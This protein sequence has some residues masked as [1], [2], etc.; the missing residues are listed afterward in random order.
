MGS[1]GGENIKVSESDA[2]E[3]S[4]TTIDIKI[5]TLDSKTFSVQVDKCVSVAELKEKIASLNGVLSE[6]QRLIC[7]G[8]VL[9]DDQLLSA[10]NVEDGHTLHLVV[11]EPVAPSPENSPDHPAIDTTSDNDNDSGNQ[12]GP[13]MPIE[14]GDGAFPDLNR[15]VSAVLNA[16]G[17]RITRFGS[18]GEGIDAGGQNTD[19]TNDGLPGSNLHDLEVLPCCSGCRG[20]RT[21][22]YLAEL[23]SSTRQL[24]GE[25]ATECLLQLEEQLNNH[26]SITDA[27]ERSRIL[28][29]AIRSGSIFQHLGSLL[30]EL[31]RVITTMQ[32]G[33][34]PADALVNAGSPVY[35][36]PTG[37]ISA[38][39]NSPRG[40]RVAD[41]H[42]RPECNTEQPMPD[43]ATQQETT[44]VLGGNGKPATPT[45]LIWM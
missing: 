16:F 2:D 11:R 30:L 43:S 28:S 19:S 9:K 35:I 15:V 20:V 38:N 25:Q 45:C 31:G 23:L 29:N 4:E 21:V 41:N 18:S 37:V 17:F 7:R 22:M 36:R 13:G 39:G 3:C 5:K 33:Q 27:L 1:N 44:Q 32:M 26:T 40:S 24:L 12:L 34:T 14:P 42:L 8:K 6:K 10:Y